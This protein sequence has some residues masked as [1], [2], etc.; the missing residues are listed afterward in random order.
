[1]VPVVMITSL[2]LDRDNIGKDC[3][4]EFDGRSMIWNRAIAI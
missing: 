4:V 2:D 3:L 1:M